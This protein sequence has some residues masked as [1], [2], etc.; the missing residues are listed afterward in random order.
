MDQRDLTRELD[1]MTGKDFSPSTA[2]PPS[3][4]ANEPAVTRTALPFFSVSTTKLLVMSLC[5]LGIYELYWFYKNWKL[6]AARSTQKISP[7]WRALFSPIFCFPLFQEIHTQVEEHAIER[8]FS[9]GALAA[10]Y[11]GL[12]LTHKLP[13]PYWL[14]CFLSIVPL[15]IVQSAVN[16]LHAQLHPSFERNSRFGVGSLAGVAGG[17]LLVLLTVLGSFGPST[18]ATPGSQLSERTRNILIEEGLITPDEN[19]LYFYSAALFSVR[20][21]GNLFTDQQ[22]VS[23][24]VV[25]GE[26]FVFAAN[27]EE[28]E[29]ID[30]NYGDGWLTDTEIT[31]RAQDGNEFLLIASGEEGGDREFVTRLMSEW[32]RHRTESL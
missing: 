19:V 11:L 28:I 26:T 9:A 23:Y 31:V 20:E 22:V 8:Q 2:P 17:S 30:V 5:T 16:E 10:I 25:E 29:A 6:V 15:M 4:A 14:V 24:E 32:K 7:F 27:Y 21:E 18:V 13:D 1:H 12:S 3:A